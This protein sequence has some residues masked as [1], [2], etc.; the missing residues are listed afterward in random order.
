M[1]LSP[2]AD[3]LS[4]KRLLIFDLDGTLVDSSPHHARAFRE[5]FAPHGI[6]VD[7][8][9]IAGMTTRAAVERLAA[10][11]GL[12]LAEGERDRLATE[13]RDR[14]LAMIETHLEPIEG[15]VE[16]VHAAQGRFALALCTS[17]SRR[18]AEASLARVGLGGWFDP[19]ITAEDV[20]RGKPHPE[21]FLRALAAHG[22]APPAALVFEDADSGIA[23]AAAAGIDA[24]RIA[25]GPGAV[26]WPTVLAALGELG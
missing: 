15:A 23:A 4:R 7:Y 9:R 6:A 24:V 5:T 10:D 18:G 3:L 17:A 19:V 13:K 22:V 21:P 8:S 25:C 1:S 14:A 26:G 12:V 16:L 11:A 20:T 2:L